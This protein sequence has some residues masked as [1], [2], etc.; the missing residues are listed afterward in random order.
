[1]IFSDFK[2]EDRIIK[3]NIGEFSCNWEK[4]SEY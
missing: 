3:D 1:M 4:F 2:K